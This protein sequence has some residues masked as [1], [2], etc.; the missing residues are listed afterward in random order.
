M[1]E[2][3]VTLQPGESKVVSFE[4][5]PR[6]A[7]VYQISVNGLTGSFKA[8]EAAPP[9]GEI[10]GVQWRLWKSDVWHPMSD[11]I[12]YSEIGVSYYL[13]FTVKNTGGK[14]SFRVGLYV[15]DAFAGWHWTY[16]PRVDIEA[17]GEA[18]IERGFDSYGVTGSQTFTFTLFADNT[19]VDS[20]AVTITIR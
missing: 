20:T 12:P 17:G 18:L 4:A 8:V 15:Y 6:E 14:A 11:L 16:S 2:Q 13:G 10:L 19:Q 1:A 9:G 3:S 5:I 7:K